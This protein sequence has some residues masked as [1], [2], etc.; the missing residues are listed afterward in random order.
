MTVVDTIVDLA[1][2]SAESILA[3]ALVPI[4]G[5]FPTDATILAPEVGTVFALRSRVILRTTAR[6][7]SVVGDR[8]IAPIVAVLQARFR[9][10]ITPLAGPL[11]QTGTLAHVVHDVTGAPILAVL[12]ANVVFAVL[13]IEQSRTLASRGSILDDTLAKVARQFTLDGCFLGALNHWRRIVYDLMV[14]RA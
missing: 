12:R 2:A 8:T 14:V 5:R 10:D 13:A 9:G 7:A 4:G 1:T 6:Q 11:R 3:F